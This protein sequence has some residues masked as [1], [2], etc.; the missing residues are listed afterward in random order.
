[1]LGWLL[2]APP[3][4]V[5]MDSECQVTGAFEPKSLF[6]MFSVDKSNIDSGMFN[7]ARSCGDRNCK[8]EDAAPILQERKPRHREIQRLA[9]VSQHLSGSWIVILSQMN[10]EVCV[11]N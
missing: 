9:H 4:V 3:E 8:A 5:R 10:V 2:E 7:W 11:P 1:M 6:L